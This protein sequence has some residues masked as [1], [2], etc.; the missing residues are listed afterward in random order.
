ME[1]VLNRKTVFGH[2]QDSVGDIVGVTLRRYE[3]FGL[4]IMRI[5][6]F[7]GDSSQG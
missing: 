2:R 1:K 7:S 4:I 5:P 6:S 3:V